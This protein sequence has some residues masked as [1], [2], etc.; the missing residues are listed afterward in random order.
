MSDKI[1]KPRKSVLASGLLSFFFGPLGWLYAAPW[2]SAL[3]G[4]AGWVL[5]VAILP[6]F[7]IMYL[8]MLVCPLSAIAGV[9]YALGFNVIGER[10]ALFG[11]SQPAAL[12]AAKPRSLGA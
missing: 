10:T 5:V 8:A 9:I 1:A 3:V 12:P 2:K 4:A 7:I 11:K 6:Q